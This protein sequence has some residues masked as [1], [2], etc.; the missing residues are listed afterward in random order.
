MTNKD[1]IFFKNFLLNQKSSLLNKTR[2]FKSAELGP[3]ENKGDDAEVASRDLSMNVSLHLVERDRTALLQIEKALGKLTAGAFGLCED[4]GQSIEIKRLK[5]RPFAA[6]CI[7]C[8]E[9][10]EDPRHFLN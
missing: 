9:E 8:M 4:C 2:E 5:A 6:L 1:V 10:H 3:L 7:D